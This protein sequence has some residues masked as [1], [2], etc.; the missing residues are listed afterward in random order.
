MNV[1]QEID[2]T[3]RLVILTISGE[4]TDQDLIALADRVA[5]TPS[6][7]KNFS[8]LVDLRFASG[9]KVTTEG[10]RKLAERPL[11]LAAESR[12]AVVVPSPLGYGMARMYEMLRGTGAT[13]VFMDY[14]EARTWVE[15]GS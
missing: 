15:A 5:N 9:L 4:I 11:V 10:V 8:M 6:I 2:H 14:D 3:R 1:D 7:N 12:R 13:K